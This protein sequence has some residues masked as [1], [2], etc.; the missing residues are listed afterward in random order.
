MIIPS[1]VPHSDPN[2]QTEGYGK[3]PDDAQHGAIATS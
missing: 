1:S 2:D 3:V